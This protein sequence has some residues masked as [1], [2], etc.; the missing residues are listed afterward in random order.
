MTSARLTSSI[1]ITIRTVCYYAQTR[2]DLLDIVKECY[3]FW[4]ATLF[5][6][7]CGLASQGSHG[8]Y[9]TFNASL[10]NSPGRKTVKSTS[11]LIF[12]HKLTDWVS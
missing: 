11:A 2:N 9:S 5:G 1:C 10:N 6:D 12:V 7:E 3:Y 4:I 8:H